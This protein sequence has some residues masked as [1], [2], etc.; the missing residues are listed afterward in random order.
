MI[1]TQPRQIDHQEE[2]A[3]VCDRS[4][5]EIVPDE[6]LEWSEA[7]RLRFTGGNGSTFD[8]S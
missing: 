5:R 2:T 1:C 7:L 4:G 3:L 8:M 6:H